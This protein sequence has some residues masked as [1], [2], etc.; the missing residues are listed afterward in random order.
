MCHGPAVHNVQ[1]SAVVGWPN[2]LV[3]SGSMECERAHTP[4]HYGEYCLD[5][6]LYHL[7]VRGPREVLQGQ[8]RSL[9][10]DP[11]G[12]L[13]RRDWAWDGWFLP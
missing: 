9:V 1:A 8:V 12:S 4:L 13:V 7:H 11:D 10:R 5:A 6:S 2:V 3:Q